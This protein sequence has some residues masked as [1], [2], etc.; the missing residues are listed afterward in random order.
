MV[1]GG[2]IEAQYGVPPDAWYF[3]ADRQPAL[4]FAVLL[5]VALQPCGWLAAYLGSALTSP[6]DLSFRNLGGSAQLCEEVRPDAGTL[7]TR[8]KITRVSSS[9]GMIIQSYEFAVSQSNRVVYE[10]ET[11]FG[12]FSKAALAQQ[13]GLRDAVIY[14]PT[15]EERAKAEALPYPIA[16]PFPDERWRMIDRIVTWLPNGGPQGLGFLQ[17]IR[18]VRPA[19]WFFQAHF[20]QDPVVPGSLGLESLL[21]LLKVAACQRWGTRGRFVV[22]TG[23]KHRWLYRGQVVPTNTSVTVTAL[24]TACDDRNR[25]LS[26]DGFLAVDGRTIYQMNDFT[27]GMV[28]DGI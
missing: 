23:G 10:G 20:Y 15:A 21:Q 19:E 4:P 8:V 14:E 17:G 18:E 28:D 13:V 6:I 2:V 7:T 22:M 3:A 11:T 26:A 1:A 24:V 5:E 9:A 27:L 12:F 25:V 16:A